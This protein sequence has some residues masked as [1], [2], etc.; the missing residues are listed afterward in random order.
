MSATRRHEASANPPVAPLKSVTVLLLAWPLVPPGIVAAVLPVLIAAPGQLPGWALSGAILVWLYGIP[1]FLAGVLLAL[2]VLL[3][4]PTAQLTRRAVRIPAVSIGLDAVGI[5]L[6]W[7][8][9][10][11]AG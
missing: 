3:T 4:R 6:H 2:A 11:H 8:L 9:G 5:A 1:W 10:P 7:L